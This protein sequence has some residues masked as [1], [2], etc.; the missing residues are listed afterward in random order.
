MWNVKFSETFSQRYRWLHREEI[1]ILLTM[2]K[3]ILYLWLMQKI[4][5]RFIFR[6]ISNFS[7]LLYFPLK[8]LVLFFSLFLI[9]LSIE[10]MGGGI[11]T[12]LPCPH[13]TPLSR[14]GNSWMWTSCPCVFPD[15]SRD[16]SSEGHSVYN[17]ST[18]MKRINNLHGG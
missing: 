5:I 13:A 6:E 3:W 4:L 16:H 9:N 11:V 12:P 18:F 2:I 15:T 14:E 7:S 10:K 1:F 17:M 8:F